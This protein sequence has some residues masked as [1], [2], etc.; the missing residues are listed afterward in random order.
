MD[1]FKFS[2]KQFA[3]YLLI[4]FKVMESEHADTNYT[5]ILVEF[6]LD[7]EANEKYILYHLRLYNMGQMVDWFK[8][9]SMSIQ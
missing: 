1:Y 4:N 6:D 7:T 5:V 9:V 2:M 3:H 8:W